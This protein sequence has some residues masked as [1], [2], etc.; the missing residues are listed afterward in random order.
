ML[1][2]LDWVQALAVYGD[3][4]N[5]GVFAPLLTDDGMPRERA[6]LLAQGA[7][8]ERNSNPVQAKQ[9]LSGALT[10][11]REH[12]GPLGRL[13][14]PQLTE[15]I[16]WFRRGTRADWELS[17]A[18]RYLARQD[19]LR[20]ITYLYESFVSHAVYRDKG[21]MNNYSDREAAFDNS[22]KN[23]NVWLLKN[24]R[25]A[26]AHGVRSDNRE[27]Q[28]LLENQ[29]ELDSRL[30]LLRKALFATRSPARS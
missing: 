21:D 24:L 22:P 6:H 14:G 29:T 20:A 12:A 1:R 16:D 5:Y 28:R 30:H 11:L 2:M 18:D 15:R 26:M 19:Y 13:F 4:G 7:F 9:A 3:S 8:F 25:N 17:L 10:D 27:I 23:A